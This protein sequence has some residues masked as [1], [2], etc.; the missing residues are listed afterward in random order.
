MPLHPKTLL[1][2]P[3]SAAVALVPP[4]GIEPATSTLGK[5]RS[6][7]LSYGGS[8]ARVYPVRF[9]I[10]MRSA[11]RRGLAGGRPPA[12]SGSKP[13][14]FLSRTARLRSNAPALHPVAV[15]RAF[16]HPEA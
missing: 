8:G 12:S 5:S 15:G 10:S 11:S 3:R 13:V 6:I 4:A 9:R 7:R 1:F 14:Q 2:P 16:Q